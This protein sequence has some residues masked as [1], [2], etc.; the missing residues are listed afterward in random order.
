MAIVLDGTGSITGLTSGAGVAA[1]ALSGQVPDANAPSG[2]IVQAKQITS[3]SIVSTTS[4]S[5]TTTGISWTFDSPLQTGSNVLVSLDVVMGQMYAGSWAHLA[6]VT[7]FENGVNRGDA[8]FG[9]AG[10]AANLGGS[11]S[12][13][14]TQYDVERMGGSCVFTPSTTNPTITL[15]FRTADANTGIKLNANWDNAIFG[16]RSAL[17]GFMMEIR[18]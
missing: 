11:T 9:I 12:S 4:T 6:Y 5:W 10:S 8:D 7:I 14:Q 18:S 3:T 15:F 1:A 17:T 13:G 2:S 16:Y